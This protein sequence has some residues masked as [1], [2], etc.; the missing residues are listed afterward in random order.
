M[1]ELLFR[2]KVGV[3][4]QRRDSQNTTTSVG[5]NKVKKYNWKQAKCRKIQENAGKYRK[6]KENTE[7]VVALPPS[8]VPRGMGKRKSSWGVLSVW[9]KDAHPD[10]FE[11]SMQ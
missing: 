4:T 7:K 5:K 2:G 3:S 10:A 8:L 1:R 9:R 11:S 6:I